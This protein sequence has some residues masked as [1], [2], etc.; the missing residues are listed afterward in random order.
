MGTLTQPLKT[1][2]KQP[3]NQ[4]K[5][6]Q[7]T[8]PK[9]TKNKTKNHHYTTTKNKT[10]TKSLP[11]LKALWNGGFKGGRRKKKKQAQSLDSKGFGEKNK[12][13]G[14]FFI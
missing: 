3:A 14:N 8:D 11:A 7:K 1:N 6:S 2:P 13:V 9:P 5:Q 12:I 4:T 10:K